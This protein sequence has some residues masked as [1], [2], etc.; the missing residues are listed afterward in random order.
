MVEREGDGEVIVQSADKRRWMPEEMSWVKVSLTKPDGT[1]AEPGTYLVDFGEH[2]FPHEALVDAGTS[3]I[4]LK[5]FKDTAFL[6]RPGEIL[7]KGGEPL[8]KISLED[9]KLIPNEEFLVNAVE[10]TQTHMMSQFL[11]LQVM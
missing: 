7:G 8:E 3:E 10:E 4:P 9:M 2:W 11:I 6:L 5:R 1:E